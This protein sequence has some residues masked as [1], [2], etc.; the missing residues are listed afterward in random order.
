MVDV[1]TVMR[2]QSR[3]PSNIDYSILLSDERPPPYPLFH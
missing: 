1:V 3:I 2:A